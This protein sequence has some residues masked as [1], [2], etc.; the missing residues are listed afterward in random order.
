MRHDGPN[1]AGQ[2]A[3]MVGTFPAAGFGDVL[4]SNPAFGMPAFRTLVSP[5][6]NVGVALEGRRARQLHRH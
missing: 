4:T 5:I 2:R 3:L 6:L 1:R